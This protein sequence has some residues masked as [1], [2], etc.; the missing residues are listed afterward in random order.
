M[1]TSWRN[2][3]IL[4]LILMSALFYG[5][6]YLIFKD[7]PFMLRLLT[8]QLGF[9]PISVILITLF[10]N[11]LIASREKR[12]RL[13]KLNMVIGSFFSEVGTPLLKS[14][15]DFDPNRDEISQE[16]LLTSEWSDAD[17]AK[18]RQYVKNHR[19]SIQIQKDKLEELKIFLMERRNFL[20]RLIENP[21]LLE[22]E[23]FT[24]LLSAIFHLTEEMANRANLRKL[25]D[26]DYEHLA[27]DIK[28]AYV[29]LFSE[30]LDYMQHLRDSYPYL[31]S[32]A[33][34][35]N[36]LNPHASVELT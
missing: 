5:L 28:R 29:A 18:A 12:T 26:A 3:L 7:P 31:Y 2:K 35:I 6:N 22:H 11:R 15:P 10:L 14:F 8:L 27:N 20:L 24:D 36:P 9:V 21:N 16:L 33:V 1:E 4:W 34:R 17:F 23:S 30:W 32:L 25:A 19:Y 13:A